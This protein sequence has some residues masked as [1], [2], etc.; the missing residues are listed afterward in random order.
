[1][2]HEKFTPTLNKPIVIGFGTGRCGTLSLQRLLDH[3]EGFTVSHEGC[4]FLPPLP[5][6]PNFN[7]AI[8]Y[9]NAQPGDMVGD[10]GWYWMCYVDRLIQMY[11]AKIIYVERDADEVAKSFWNIKKDGE[12]YVKIPKGMIPFWRYPFLGTEF[13]YEQIR[14]TVELWQRAAVTLLSHFPKQIYA[15]NID[16]LNDVGKVADMLLWLGIPE[17]KI[18]PEVHHANKARDVS[19]YNEQYAFLQSKARK[20]MEDEEMRDGAQVVVAGKV[21]DI[22][23]GV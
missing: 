14:R 12:R 23:K 15:M 11:D 10:V 18:R 13:S 7:M 5:V 1:M 6:S 4:S 8:K 21:V 17:P 2:E 22:Y 20:W 3:Q 16:D 9:F 19:A